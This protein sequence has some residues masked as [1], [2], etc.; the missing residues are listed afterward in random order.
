MEFNNEEDLNDF[1]INGKKWSV[2]KDSYGTIVIQ[3]I[4]GGSTLT[5]GASEASEVTLF[6]Y[7]S[8][9]SKPE[10]IKP[11]Q[12]GIDDVV[13]EGGGG[14]TPTPSVKLTGFSF[15][16]S[17]KLKVGDSRKLRINI[18]PAGATGVNYSFSVANNATFN[19]GLLVPN[20]DKIRCTQKYSILEVE[21]LRQSKDVIITA[22]VNQPS[23]DLSYSIKCNVEIEDITSSNFDLNNNTGIRNIEFQESLR[24]LG[25]ELILPDEGKEM[26]FNNT[27]LTEATLGKGDYEIHN[28]LLD[29]GLIG[30]NIDPSELL[31]KGGDVIYPSTITQKDG[32]LFLGNV[33]LTETQTTSFLEAKEIFQAYIKDNPGIWTSRDLTSPAPIYDSELFTV[34]PENASNSKAFK[35]NETYRFGIQLQDNQGKWT[36]AIPLLDTKCTGKVE[37]SKEI[38]INHL[39]RPKYLIE[40]PESIQEKLKLLGYYK[41]R[42]LVVLPTEL[43]REIIAQGI[44]NST[45]YNTNQR[46]N[47]EFAAQSSWFFRP[48][49][50]NYGRFGICNDQRAIKVTS[51][52][53]SI[54]ENNIYKDVDITVD[55]N[56]TV[57]ISANSSYWPSDF[58]K[59]TQASAGF[60]IAYRHHELIP[61]SFCRNSEFPHIWYNTGNEGLNG[62]ITEVNI[63]G[64]T[65]Y[66]HTVDSIY[67]NGIRDYYSANKGTKK[68][69]WSR[70][71]YSVDCSILTFHSP[72]IEFNKISDISGCKFRLVGYSLYSH[73]VK[74]IDIQQEGAYFNISEDTKNGRT[75]NDTAISL[76]PSYSTH[77]TVKFP[78]TLKTKTSTENYPNEDKWPVTFATYTWNYPN[79][80]DDEKYKLK[81]NKSSHLHVFDTTKYFDTPH[82]LET[83]DAKIFDSSIDTIVLKFPEKANWGN[84]AWAPSTKNT[85][86]YKGNVNDIIASFKPY[87]IKFYFTPFKNTNDNANYQ[88]TLN[89]DSKYP[90]MGT[91]NNSGS[92]SYN[93]GFYIIKKTKESSS[94]GWSTEKTPGNDKGAELYKTSQPIQLTYKSSPHGV[95]VLDCITRPNE[96]FTRWLT[97]PRMD[98][99]QERSVSTNTTSNYTIDGMTNT[100][101]QDNLNISLPKD[102]RGYLYIG[103]LYRD[104]TP[105]E[106]YGSLD[107]ENNIWTV[108]GK[109][110]SIDEK[111]IQY[112]EGDT[113]LSQYDCLKTYPRNNTDFNQVTEIGTFWVETRVNTATRYDNNRNQVSNMHVSPNN[114]NKFNPVYDQTDNFFTYRTIKDDLVENT[115]F[116]HTIVWS[117]QKIKGDK[118]DTWTNI[119][120]TATLDLDGIDGNLVKLY[121]FNNEIFSFQPK[122][123]NHIL[124]NSRVQINSSDGI[125]IEIQNGYRVDGARKI[126]SIGASHI[127]CIND[128]NSSVFFTDS[129]TKGIYTFNGSVVESLSDKLNFSV[130]ASKNITNDSH[131]YVDHTNKN[132]YIRNI[133]SNTKEVEV[134]GYSELLGEFESFYDYSSPIFKTNTST[135][136]LSIDDIIEE[137]VSNKSIILYK[138]YSNT[139]KSN[140]LNFT[141]SYIS[142][143]HN[144][145][146]IDNK[147]YSHIEFK[148]DPI[149]KQDN[150]YLPFKG[151]KVDTQDGSSDIGTGYTK[152]I[153]DKYRPSNLKKKFNSWRIEIPRRRS[154]RFQNPWAKISLYLDR[155]ASTKN[156]EIGN[157]LGYSI[158]YLDVYFLE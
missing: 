30:Y 120:M 33:T 10:T 83:A 153:Y 116:P 141:D 101:W 117:K 62:N 46:C 156:N 49:Q 100:I 110:V 125:P 25:I 148:A 59:K 5:T 48:I 128:N 132:I 85:F 18:E 92:Y 13:V 39:Y 138:L 150:F 88:S 72:E 126:S 158:P 40:I 55:N 91:I 93:D 8:D 154:I 124:F 81:V 118:I 142:I 112:T 57:V 109:S 17:I 104:M 69:Y 139:N 38:N 140:D 29:T 6:A 66:Y 122:G 4:S 136:T 68:S 19:D 35:R 121:N 32:T 155:T 34:L 84:T 15:P 79:M 80:Y 64:K 76:K 41:I 51:V 151:I 146:S 119:N 2:Y 45:V 97:L 133:N 65:E 14:S 44:V 9:L 22:I 113:F 94:P 152:L 105:E 102:H 95:I 52:K 23:Y 107:N 16:S 87:A 103:E 60:P 12:P 144:N 134:L 77:T 127:K 63:D 145:S 130:W 24:E 131:V 149:E 111:A 86:V 90:I 75:I 82:L 98:E 137:G 108:A 99:Y 114:F 3:F 7:A 47:T 67:V 31:Y 21:A 70:D 78:V 56:K 157:E 50:G 106:K 147:C 54:D 53:N 123:I 20:T 89:S 42:P 1:K 11:F 58:G 43:N 27:L 36:P 143:I 26:Y 74:G 73:A 37:F 96:N 71:Y 28:T 115:K 135:Y 61:P 129:L